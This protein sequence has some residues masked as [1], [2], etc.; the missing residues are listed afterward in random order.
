VRAKKSSLPP[1][2]L[3]RC[4]ELRKSSSSDAEQKLWACLRNRQLFGA[5]FRRQAPVGG[6]ILD[7]YCFEAGLAIE[8]DGGQHAEP[9]QEAYDQ[10]RTRAME[11]EGIRVLRFW[12][13]EVLKNMEEALEVIADALTLPSPEGRGGKRGSKE[14]RWSA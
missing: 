8:L 4:R 12:N 5:K 1:E 2:L 13:H 10:E 14:D 9:S 11:R 3:A 6:F 7:F